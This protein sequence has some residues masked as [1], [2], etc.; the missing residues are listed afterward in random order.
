MLNFKI[1]KNIWL[2]S[3]CMDDASNLFGVID[4]NRTYLRQWL[5]WVDKT[6]AIK[7]I[8]VFINSAT[9]RIEPVCCIVNNE[10]ILGICGFKPINQE[11]HS[12]EIGYWLLPSA[13]GKGI[14]TQCVKTLM[15]H[16]F[17]EL[18]INRIILK[19]ATE[20]KRSRAV[21]ERLGFTQEGTLR[22][23]E[24]LNDRYVD[25]ALYSV[26]KSEWGKREN[27]AQ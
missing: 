27:T 5:G 11:N 15:G 19:A 18:Q 23:D 8:E 13:T 7:D 16:A 12:V 20:N 22:E 2:R 24:W 21:A 26:L 10:E 9:D 4:A 3:I 1:N 14:M 25:H 17:E 6:L